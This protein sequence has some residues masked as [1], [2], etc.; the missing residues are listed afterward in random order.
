MFTEHLVKITHYHKEIA[1]FQSGGKPIPRRIQIDPVSFCNHDCPFCTYRYTRDKDVNA[2]FDL[3]DMI[4]YNKMIEIFNDCAKSGVKAIELT[5]GGEPS[6]HPRFVDL[7]KALNDRE[8]EIGLITNGSWRPKDMMG[9][10]RE[11]RNAEWV[12]FSLDAATAETHQI[13][14]AS[15]RD[16]FDRAISAIKYL[17]GHR[18]TVGISFI[19]Q[20][21]N[22]H[23]IRDAVHLAEEL[24]VDYIRI[25]GV[26]FE[27]ERI[28]HIEL[29]LEEHEET[30]EL[31]Q[32]LVK[33]ADVEVWDNFT[34]RSCA[35]YGVYNEGDT[36]FLS[37]LA[38]T[39]GADL[40]VYPCCIWK[41]RPDGVIADL[42]DVRLSEV[43]ENDLLDKF[44]EKFDLKEKCVRC[45]LK[46]KNDFIAQALNSRHVNFI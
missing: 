1:E 26:M 31:V 18:A 4:P 21:Q 36:C 19:V 35:D 37:Y 12:R 22:V 8:L 45:F 33:T 9:A 27:G 39:I 43:W 29:S 7:L 20:K 42:N 25:G 16:D 6:L 14:H 11:L 3:K 40:R 34:D 23:E 10:I 24:G 44:Y 32:E 30:A 38:L 15:K 5:G 17:I 41:Y 2:L 46:D 28:D 13:T